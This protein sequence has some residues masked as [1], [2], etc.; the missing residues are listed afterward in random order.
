MNKKSAK[1][2]IAGFLAAVMALGTIGCSGGNSTG[3]SSVKAETASSAGG[4]LS[5]KVSDK[6]V[7]FTMLYADN[8]TYPFKKDWPTL[9]KMTELTNVSLNVTVVPDADYPTKVQLLLNSGD[10]PDIVCKTGISGSV[11]DMA[12]NGKLLSF[13]DYINNMSNFQ[14][15]VKKSGMNDELNNTKLADGKIYSLP[16]NVNEKRVQTEQ[17][18]VRKDI[19]DKNNMPLPT[20][21]EECYR[22]LKALKAKNPSLI[23]I[24]NIY[25]TGDL[26]CMVAGSYNTIAGWDGSSFSGFQY[27]S[28]SDKW[29][30]APTSDNYKSMLK[31][32]HKL[33]SEGL[34]DKEF[35]TLDTT[36]FD[37]RV[38]SGKTVMWDGWLGGEVTYNRDGK[39]TDPNFNVVPIPA[40][41]GPKGTAGTRVTGAWSQSMICPASVKDK[42]Y[43]DT[44]IKWLDWMY[45][46]TAAN[47]FSWGIKGE[48][49]TV[50]QDGTK[51]YTSDINSPDN[52]SGTKYLGKDYGC[53]NNNLSFFYPYDYLKSTFT[54]TDLSVL[55]TETAKKMLVI[56]QPSLRLTSD[57]KDEE[58]LVSTAL[59]DYV[60]S[61]DEKFIMGKEP[62][63]NWDNY[64]KECDNKGRAKLTKL[65][66]KVWQ[67]QKMSK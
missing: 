14:Q 24:Q 62:F 2:A 29:I 36:A 55:E 49:Y 42:P 16:V 38:I 35:A 37:Q 27:D 66:N 57:D 4:N 15:A 6:P 46:D 54:K 30:H 3:A 53:N 32:L 25:Q 50:K 39:K 65:Y 21:W 17:W 64:V 31:F 47:L 52:P 5:G 11:E 9:K 56:P 61:E 10:I 26:L 59:T 19:F 8:S 45:S 48:T 63:S 12:L 28:A 7:T 58:N 33:Y 18:F 60:S 44:L 41:A 13:S 1:K 43:F 22:D 40:L 67:R 23:P 34:L 20:S 51:A